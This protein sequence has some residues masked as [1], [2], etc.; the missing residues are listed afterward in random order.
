MSKSKINIW[1][2]KLYNFPI[3]HFQNSKKKTH[4]DTFI[5]HI[6]IENKKLSKLFGYIELPTY[7]VD[8]IKENI[9]SIVASKIYSLL[10][11]YIFS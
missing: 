9:F 7:I 11:R 2:H 3:I 8:A 1:F 6:Y 4:K 10:F 5:I